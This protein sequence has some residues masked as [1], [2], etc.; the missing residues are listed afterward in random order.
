ML[1]FW[2]GW[3]F[4][5]VILG[6]NDGFKG[7]EDWERVTYPFRMAQSSGLRESQESWGKGVSAV[8]KM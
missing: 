7:V 3:K 1:R 4:T 6:G 5:K 2:G 8:S